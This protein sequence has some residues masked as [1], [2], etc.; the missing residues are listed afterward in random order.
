MSSALT[1]ERLSKSYGSTRAVDDLSIDVRE[2]CTFG[3][4]GRNGAGKTTAISCILGLVRPQSGTILIHGRRL[5]TEMLSEI[6]Y[7]PE[8]PS[9][10]GFMTGAEH[11][12]MQR[13]VYQ[14]FDLA[15]SRELRERFELPMRK[16]VR[17]LS[18]GQRTAL[19]LLLAF[20]QK[21]RLLVLDEPSSGLDPFMQRHLLALIV[22][23][24]LE[25]RTVLF[26]SHQ[27]GQ[28]ERSAEVVA[29][30]HRG[31]IA[32]ISDLESL[33]ENRKVIEASFEHSVPTV[34]ALSGDVAIR[35]IKSEGNVV[36]FSVS[37]DAERIAAQV[38]ALSPISL[39]ILDTSLETIFFETTES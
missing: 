32:M 36:R 3:L 37:S 20:A 26:S 15:M 13:R 31:R 4:L 9:L 23:S 34:S 2:G 33:R 10:F 17:L 24:G 22:E 6:A 38:A 27:I 7:V 8:T 18:K 5:T 14:H 28:I 29:I 16:R 11:V 30:M 19:A 25:G 21:S 39:R 12:E 35:D 1:V